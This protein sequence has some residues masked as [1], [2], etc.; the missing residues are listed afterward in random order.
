MTPEN[1]SKL[2]CELYKLYQE[3]GDAH[4]LV[5]DSARLGMLIERTKGSDEE[6]TIQDVFDE[7]NK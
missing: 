2:K 1:I 5:N 3:T 4:S 7:F 6:V